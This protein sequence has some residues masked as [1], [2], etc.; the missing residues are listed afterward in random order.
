M[1]NRWWAKCLVFYLLLC[2][3]SYPS[4]ALEIITNA[5]IILQGISNLFFMQEEIISKIMYSVVLN[6]KILQQCKPM[7]P[8]E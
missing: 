4:G 1:P 7:K 5:L 3:Q 8:F 2:W 6:R